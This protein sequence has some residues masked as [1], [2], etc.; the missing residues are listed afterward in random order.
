MQKK[1]INDILYNLLTGSLTESD[2]EQLYAWLEDNPANKQHF[3][4]LMNSEDFV[5]NYLL[6]HTIDKEA[7]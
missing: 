2:Q 7:A 4:E 5:S 6:Y 3:K 1:D